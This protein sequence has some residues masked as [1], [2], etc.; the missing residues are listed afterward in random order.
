MELSERKKLLIFLHIAQNPI[1]LSFGG[2]GYLN[3]NTFLLVK[4]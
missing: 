4:A 1:E 3:L 2:L